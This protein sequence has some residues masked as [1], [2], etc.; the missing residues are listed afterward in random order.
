[1]LKR[2]QFASHNVGHIIGFR[3]IRSKVSIDGSGGIIFE[4]SAI[5]TSVLDVSNVDF[6]NF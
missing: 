5:S 1:M 2:D 4:F 6:V 3:E